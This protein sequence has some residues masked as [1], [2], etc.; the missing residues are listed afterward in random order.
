[1]IIQNDFAEGGVEL[2]DCS[3]Q[4]EIVKTT[5]EHIKR[6]YYWI[7]YDLVCIECDMSWEEH[8]YV[9]SKGRDFKNVAG[10][11]LHHSQ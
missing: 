1:M 9:V 11:K 6:E 7:I 3:C 10:G 8:I 2:C 4:Q 5:V